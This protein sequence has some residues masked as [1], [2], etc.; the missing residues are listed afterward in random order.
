[1]GHTSLKIDTSKLKDL[2]DDT[3]YTICLNKHIQFIE[4]RIPVWMNNALDKNAG[5]WTSLDKPPS[6]DFDGNYESKMP[7][8]IISMIT[9][10]VCIYFAHAA[11]VCELTIH[12]LLY[13][14]S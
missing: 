1:M 7:N 3:H 13:S 12:F 6:V 5:E 9:Q 11:T 8:D 4:Q 10:E 2:L 14:L